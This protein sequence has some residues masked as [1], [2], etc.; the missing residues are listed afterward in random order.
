L[1]GT[2]LRKVLD[3]ATRIIITQSNTMN[4]KSVL[5]CK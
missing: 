1:E 4:K 2:G 3:E 5:S